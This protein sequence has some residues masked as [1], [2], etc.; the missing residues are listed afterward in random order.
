MK[1]V[2]SIIFCIVLSFTAFSQN[3]LVAEPFTGT[4]LEG[5]E[6]N[7]D[8]L[9]GKVVV[10]TFWSTRCAICHDEIP[11]LNK[12][13]DKY[14]GKDVIFMGLTIENETRV[15]L[16]LKKKPFKFTIVPNSLGVIS[17][18]RYNVSTSK[19]PV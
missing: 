5:K 2:L 6:I 1:I 4:S 10:M 3:R 18:L 12:V 8:N 17:P 19:Y 13:A 9:R 15:E 16:Y 7:L 11:K 14:A